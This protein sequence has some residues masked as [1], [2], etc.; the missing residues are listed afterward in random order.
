MSQ[1]QEGDAKLTYR[2]EGYTTGSPMPT[3]FLG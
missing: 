3:L 1:Q 2:V